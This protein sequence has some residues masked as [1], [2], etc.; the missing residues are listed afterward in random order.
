MIMYE[1]DRTEVI[2]PS[3]ILDE[4]SSTMQRESAEPLSTLEIYAGEF[5]ANFWEWEH[6]IH[7]GS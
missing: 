4:L 1:I 7:E 6:A 3:S 5:V 2:M